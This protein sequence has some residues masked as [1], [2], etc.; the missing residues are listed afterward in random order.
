MAIYCRVIIHEE[1]KEAKRKSTMVGACI[2]FQ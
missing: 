2:F 1:L